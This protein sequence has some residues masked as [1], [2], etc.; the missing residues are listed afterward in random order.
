M[1][2]ALPLTP[3]CLHGVDT[4]NFTFYLLQLLSATGARSAAQTW[5][6]VTDEN[7]GANFTT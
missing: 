6:R 7:T 2:A 5:F 3:L 4:D 1:S